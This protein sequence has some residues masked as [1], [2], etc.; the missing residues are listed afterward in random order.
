LLPFLEITTVPAITALPH[1]HR[2]RWRLRFAALPLCR[3]H[4]SVAGC[5]MD[6]SSEAAEPSED[7]GTHEVIGL[8]I[9]H[10]LCFIL[11]LVCDLENTFSAISSSR[12]QLGTF[13]AAF[14][15]EHHSLRTIHVCV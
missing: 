10:D 9:E 2:Q 8:K 6:Q 13:Q 3:A 1:V 5:E 14:C 15:S 4:V 11:Y 12:S 7:P